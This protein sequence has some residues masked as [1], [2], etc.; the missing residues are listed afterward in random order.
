MSE[1]ALKKATELVKQK[2]FDEALDILRPLVPKPDT[3]GPAMY[4]MGYVYEKQGDLARAHYLYTQSLSANPNQAVVLRRLE[5]FETMNVKL[6]QEIGSVYDELEFHRSCWSCNLRCLD[7]GS[8]CLYCGAPADEPPERMRDVVIED[9]TAMARNAKD[10]AGKLGR[11]VRDKV[12]N[13]V[14]ADDLKKAKTKAVEIG[15]QSAEKAKAFAERDDVQDAAKRARK[16]GEEAMTK[17]QHYVDDEREKYDKADEEGRK[18]L[19]IKWGAM[20]GV[21]LI[22]YWMF[23]PGGCL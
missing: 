8:S 21:L 11:E 3:Q 12:S 17:A 20:F 6:K 10:Q 4:V 13:L 14:D 23:G 5:K 22:L 7:D 15:K 2:S 19:L 16:L 9:A 18:A 1:E